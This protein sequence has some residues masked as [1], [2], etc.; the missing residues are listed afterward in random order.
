MIK[1]CIKLNW[2]LEE[3]WKEKREKRKLK[4]GLT[5]SKG[6]LHLLDCVGFGVFCGCMVK[7]SF[8]F[9]FKLTYN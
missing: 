3:A 2:A 5:F 4:T 9:F 7:F 8:F 1:H 6:H